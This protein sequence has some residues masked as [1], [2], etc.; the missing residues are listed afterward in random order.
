VR[1]L[2][3]AELYLIGCSWTERRM[4]TSTRCFG[5]V[6]YSLGVT[7]ATMDLRLLNRKY[8]STIERYAFGVGK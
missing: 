3:R 4:E 2:V 5:S 8:C 7:C 6:Y 1:V